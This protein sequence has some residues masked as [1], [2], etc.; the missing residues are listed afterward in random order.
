MQNINMWFFF[1]FFL[2]FLFFRFAADDHTIVRSYIHIGHCLL[3]FCFVLFFL[4]NFCLFCFWLL[5]RDHEWYWEGGG[6]EN[7]VL[8]FVA[9]V[10]RVNQQMLAKGEMI[11]KNVISAGCHSHNQLSNKW[12]FCFNFSYISLLAVEFHLLSSLA[13]VTRH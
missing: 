7:F 12:V 11:A 10:H 1:L 8:E 9:I 13:L 5:L 3:L 4:L 2:I 6:A